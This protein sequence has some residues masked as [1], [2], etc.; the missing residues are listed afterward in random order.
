KSKSDT[1]DKLKDEPKEIKQDKVI[2][3]EEE[4]QKKEERKKLKERNTKFITNP[5]ILKS[6]HSQAIL[7]EV[8]KCVAEQ[9]TI[10]E[11]NTLLTITVGGQHD[12]LSQY[13]SLTSFSNS[14]IA[15]CPSLIA[16]LTIC[17]VMTEAFDDQNEKQKKEQLNEKEGEQEIRYEFNLIK[18]LHPIVDIVGSIFAK[19]NETVSSVGKSVLYNCIECIG[20]AL[21]NLFEQQDGEQD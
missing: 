8:L 4:K 19:I 10:Q 21:S 16:N 7:N 2:I 17:R 11:L 15:I 3:S 9:I 20:I 5:F 6:E 1:K 13:P 14:L 18:I 12:P